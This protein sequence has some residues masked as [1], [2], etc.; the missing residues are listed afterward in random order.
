[1]AYRFQIHDNT[2][3]GEVR[4]RLAEG[5]AQALG[6][7]PESE[8]TLSRAMLV[9]VLLGYDLESDDLQV[10]LGNPDQFYQ[11]ALAVFVEYFRGLSSESPVVILL[12]D[13]HWADTS[14]LEVL[15]HISKNLAGQ[16]LLVVS[17][18]RQQIFEQYPEWGKGRRFHT[19]LRPQAALHHREPRAGGR[20]PAEG[21]SG[22]GG[23]A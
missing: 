5:I 12:E 17:T 11:R 3:P 19:F 23:A 18:A 21:G 1:M 7:P 22:A 15:D 4:E 2:A 20:D 8:K 13:V 16:S 14:S 9:G 6:V 10:R